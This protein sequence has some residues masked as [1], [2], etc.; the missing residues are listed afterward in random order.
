M[1]DKG[2]S[3]GGCYPGTSCYYETVANAINDD[4]VLSGPVNDFTAA[5]YYYKAADLGSKG[6]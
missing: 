1:S 6:K 5:Y 2:E 3:S 4:D